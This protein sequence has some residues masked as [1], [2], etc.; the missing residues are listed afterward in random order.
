MSC[1]SCWQKHTVN[2][3][4]SLM[5]YHPTYYP[6]SGLTNEIIIAKNLWFSKKGI[7]IWK[8]Y[9]NKNQDCSSITDVVCV[10]VLQL[11]W[12]VL[13]SEFYIRNLM[14][15]PLAIWTTNNCVLTYSH[16]SGFIINGWESQTKKT[17][18]LI[19]DIL[20]DSEISHSSYIAIGL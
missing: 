10:F 6:L 15:L 17:W 11:N 14:H 13:G 16:A 5:L 19:M 2:Y 1:S 4:K 3:I 18:V 9:E 12:Y 8:K 7:G 20:H